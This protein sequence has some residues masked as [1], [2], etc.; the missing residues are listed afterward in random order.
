M[1]KYSE[2]IFI[3]D[4]KPCEWIFD[5]L[6]TSKQV[7][8]G[9]SEHYEFTPSLLAEMNAALAATR[10][11]RSNVEWESSMWCPRQDLNLYPVKD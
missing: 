4:G 3:E 10:S 8:F 11:L 2:R 1:R 9:F 6:I 7:A 5:R